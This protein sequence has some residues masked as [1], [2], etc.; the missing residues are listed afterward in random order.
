MLFT[1]SYA[2]AVIADSLRTPENEDREYR[3]SAFGKTGD[4]C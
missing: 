3:F 4:F 2:F 1:L